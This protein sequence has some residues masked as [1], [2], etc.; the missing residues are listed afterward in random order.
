MA[1]DSKDVLAGVLG[2]K[3]GFR[4]LVNGPYGVQEVTNLIAILRLY[5]RV[6]RGETVDAFEEPDTDKA[7]AE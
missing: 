3:T 6:M 1:E 4:L 5:Q 2:E 7:E